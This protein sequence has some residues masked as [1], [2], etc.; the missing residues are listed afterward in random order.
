MGYLGKNSYGAETYYEEVI[1]LNKTNYDDGNNFD[2]VSINRK[3]TREREMK[4]ITSHQTEE[5][6]HVDDFYYFYLLVSRICG[7]Q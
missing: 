2:E 1:R 6:K 7:V 4:L 5:E 3:F